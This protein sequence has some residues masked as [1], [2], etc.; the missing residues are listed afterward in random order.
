MTERIAAK[1]VEDPS[2]DLGFGRV[3]SEQRALRLLNRDG[4]FNVTSPETIASDQA[5][6]PNGALSVY[7]ADLDQDGLTDAV[8]LDSTSGGMQVQLNQAIGN[9]GPGTFTFTLGAGITA[10]VLRDLNGDGVSDVVV[11]NSQTGQ[12]TIVLSAPPM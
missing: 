12:V 5:A 10:A 9:G 8:V 4:T 1:T 3:V 7:A 2:S 11:L 6:N